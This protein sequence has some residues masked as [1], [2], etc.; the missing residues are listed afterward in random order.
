MPPD[1]SEIT[2]AVLNYNGRRFLDVVLPSIFR[3][4]LEGFAVHLVDDASTDDSVRYV[5]DRWPEVRLIVSERNLNVTR[6]MQRAIDTART[7]YVALL[8]NDLELDERW[9]E[10][11][12]AELRR[13]PDA[14]AV[15][16]KML[17]FHDRDVIDGAGDTYARHGFAARRGHG[18]RD[19]GQ[20][21][22]VVETFS[23]SGGAALYR[24]SA[25]ERVG[26]FDA[27]FDAYYEDVDWGFRARL[28]GLTAWYT[29][30]AIAYHMGSATTGGDPA[31]F[32]PRLVR[33]RLT[34]VVKAYPAALLARCLPRIVRAELGWWSE[35][36]R[37][38]R[39]G[40]YLR[41]VAGAARRLP[42]TLAKRRPIQRSR[43]VAARDLLRV[44]E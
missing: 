6:S 35:S 26:P 21:D 1:G 12:L 8:N 44:M 5:A 36:R 13:H 29:P 2:V 37:Q 4:T 42:R 32:F 38:G 25:F 43:T 14:A 20:Y 10:E 7:P 40:L 28:L 11:A 3:Q 16:G 24:R 39:T 34:V 27:D 17:S 31:R 41:G 15:D 23:A 9:L 18:E 30:R 19:E 22:A 33:N